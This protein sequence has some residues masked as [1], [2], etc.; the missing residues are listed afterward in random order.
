LL[1]IDDINTIV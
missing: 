1:Q